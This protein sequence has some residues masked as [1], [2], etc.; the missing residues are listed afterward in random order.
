MLVAIITKFT[1]IF[2]LYPYLV[3]TWK[4]ICLP[5]DHDSEFYPN[6]NNWNW[7]SKSRS[8]TNGLK[9][10]LTSFEHVVAFLLPKEL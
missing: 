6:G 1:T 7:D 4:Q 5:A 3:K 2:E 8:T 10:I 9:H